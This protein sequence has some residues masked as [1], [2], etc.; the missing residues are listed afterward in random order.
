MPL[1]LRDALFQNRVELAA[2]RAR[3]VDGRGGRATRLDVDG[4]VGGGGELA[5]PAA[6]ADV[7]RD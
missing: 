5:G 7:H 6:V 2:G 3:R 4:A 1:V